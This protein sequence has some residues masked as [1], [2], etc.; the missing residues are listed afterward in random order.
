LGKVF[1][2]KN[3]LFFF[4]KWGPLSSPASIFPFHFEKE[5]M[6]RKSEGSPFVLFSVFL[7]LKRGER[8][9]QKKKEQLHSSNSLFLIPLQKVREYKVGGPP[10][11]LPLFRSLIP[12]S[13]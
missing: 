10:L 5:E 4:Q 11:P 9:K 7:F 3:F 13:F 2:N 8:K 1:L 6:S 12:F